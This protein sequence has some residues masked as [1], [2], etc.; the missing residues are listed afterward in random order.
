MYLG[1]VQ[2]NSKDNFISKIINILECSLLLPIQQ[3]ALISLE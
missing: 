3:Q 2:D 1:K